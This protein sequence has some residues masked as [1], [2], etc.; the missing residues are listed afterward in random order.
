[1]RTPPPLSGRPSKPNDPMAR[2]PRPGLTGDELPEVPPANR[3]LPRLPGRN[4]SKSRNLDEADAQ[5]SRLPGEPPV[6]PGRFGTASKLQG[7]RD[8]RPA[9][10]PG[11]LESEEAPLERLP[12]LT[13]RLAAGAQAGES[14]LESAEQAMRQG[15]AGRGLRPADQRGEPSRA[16]DRRARD[17]LRGDQ[18][19]ATV[20]FV[21]DSGL[22]VADETAPPVIERPTQQQPAASGDPAVR[23]AGQSS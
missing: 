2:P 17:P 18:P 16:A 20:D 15:L 1:M 19:P 3:G 5:R 8:P 4:D 9:G 11:S 6:G 14:E 22:F 7:I 12:T 23:L 10:R 21:G 13:S